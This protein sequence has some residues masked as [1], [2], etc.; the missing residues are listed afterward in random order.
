[1]SI[2]WTLQG[3]W[4]SGQTLLSPEQS[5][6][7]AQLEI[8]KISDKLKLRI[9]HKKIKQN[10]ILTRLTEKLSKLPRTRKVWNNPKE[11]V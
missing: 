6:F 4:E 5:P 7:C 8:K 1:M 2:E 3:P 10:K 11:E 9:F